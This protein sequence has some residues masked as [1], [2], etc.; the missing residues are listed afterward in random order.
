MDFTHTEMFIYGI[1]DNKQLIK[2][3]NI[4]HAHESI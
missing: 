4:L 3:Y 1:S 2:M